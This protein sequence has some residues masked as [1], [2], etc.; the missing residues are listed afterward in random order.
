[1]KIKLNKYIFKQKKSFEI[2]KI[3]QRCNFECR[4][5]GNIFNLD[6]S[7]RYYRNFFFFHFCCLNA[8]AMH[9]YW[10]T[11]RGCALRIQFRPQYS[12]FANIRCFQYY[13]IFIKIYSKKRKSYNCH[14]KRVLII[15]HDIIKILRIVK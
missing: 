5:Q 6:E 4:C 2:I 1:M 8:L 11:K 15:V 9:F 12:P 7:R 14:V 10:S 3:H 13:T